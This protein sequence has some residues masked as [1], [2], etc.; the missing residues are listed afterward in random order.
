MSLPDT[1]ELTY[2]YNV[3]WIQI[4]SLNTLLKEPDYNYTWRILANSITADQVM[5]LCS[6]Y[7]NQHKK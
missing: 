5:V 4:T 1:S 6:P 7:T 2:K 3:I